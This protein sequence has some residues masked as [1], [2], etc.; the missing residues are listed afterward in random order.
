MSAPQPPT[1]TASQ[2]AKKPRPNPRFKAPRDGLG[3]YISHP[4]SF[5]PT[6]VITHNENFVYI[7]DMYPKSIIHTLLLPRDQSKTKLHPFDAFSNLEF[8]RK[9]MYEAKK[10]KA[11]VAEE[12]KRL[13]GEQEGR[14][15][16]QEVKVG[17]HAAPSMNH[18]HVH[19]LSRDCVSE[20]LKT[21]KHY[22]SFNTP[23]FI[24]LDEF[25]LAEDDE[26][27]N[28]TR[29]ALLKQEL[30]CWRC[31]KSFKNQIKQLK[32]HLDEEFEEWKKTPKVSAAKEG[33]A[34]SVTTDEGGTATE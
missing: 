17:V 27:R 33:K 31:G 15:W 22:N 5:P 29:G 11:L 16:E 18:L 19:V 25:P 8:L 24:E 28:P 10:L 6:A 3:P 14:D 13:F 21:V 20:R 32:E 9:T 23:F 2:P 34:K 26:R 1:F 7:R 30:Q 12:L 4:T